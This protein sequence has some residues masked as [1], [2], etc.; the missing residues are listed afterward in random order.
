VNSLRKVIA[1]QYAMRSFMIFAANYS[2]VSTLHLS[3][4]SMKSLRVRRF[5]KLY[6]RILLSRIFALSAGWLFS[7]ALPAAIY[8]GPQVLATTNAGQKT[9][10]IATSFAFLLSHL[11]AKSLLSSYPGGRSQGL[12][13]TQV[14]IC[15]GAV[16]IAT[17]ILRTEVSR[18]LLLSSGGAAFVWFQIEYLTTRIYFRPKLAVISGGFAEGVLALPNCDMRRLTH[19]DLHNV[20]YDGIV[21]DFETLN[22]DEERFLT[23]CALAG[24]PVYNAKTVYESLTGR[25]K[26]EKMSENII[27]S[28]LPSPTYEFFKS[29]IDWIIVVVTLPLSLLIGIMT[30]IIIRIESPGSVIY[31]QTRVGRGNKIFTIYKFRSMRFD[32]DAVEQFAGEDD[33]RITRVGKIIRKLRIDELPQF[34]NIIKGEMSLIGPRPEQPSFVNEFDKR[35]PFYSYRH[36]VKPGIT[37]WAQVRHGYAADSDQTRVKIEHDFYY[38]KNCSLSMDFLIVF[39]TIKTIFSGFGAR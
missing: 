13:S 34:L 31:S 35:I 6:E 14:L 39:L 17:L 10:L 33:P 2:W 16:I 37:G 1:S 27:G 5:K 22:P 15:Y 24:I 36:V 12:I 8:W 4:M 23:M 30:A 11:C 19:L 29:I 21:A 3:R 7:V 9:A 18:V 26:I 32:K 28:L 38:I 20:R 25:V